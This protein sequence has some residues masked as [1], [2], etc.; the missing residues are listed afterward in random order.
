M[1]EP[2][3][4]D[5][6]TPVTTMHLIAQYTRVKPLL[7]ALRDVARPLAARRGDQLVSQDIYDQ[8]RHLLAD[9]QRVVTSQRGA[10]S[11][12][13]LRHC[14]DWATLLSK[15]ELALTALDVFRATYAAY[16]KTY[17]AVVWR[18]EIWRDLARRGSESVSAAKH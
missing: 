10:R 5:I 8:A 1:S 3:S 2:L 6:A 17:G 18:D 14:P 16:D 11:L 12:L 9:V 7:V 15:L 4:L 13:V